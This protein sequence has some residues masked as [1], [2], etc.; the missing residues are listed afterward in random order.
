MSHTLSFYPAPKSAKQQAAAKWWRALRGLALLLAYAGAVPAAAQTAPSALRAKAYILDLSQRRITLPERTFYIEQVVDGRAGRPPIGM[1]YRGMYD[2]QAPVL[3]R[4]SLEAEL[5]TWLQQQFPKRPTDHTVVL[6]VRQLGV[7]ET[8]RGTAKGA[9]ASADL[10]AD[11]YEHQSD[12][13]HF[14]RT[15]A[16]RVSDR[17]IGDNS[18]HAE[19]LASAL[20]I[21]LLQVLPTDW[22]RPQPA[23]SLAQLAS[24]KPRGMARPA[25]LRAAT[26]RRGLYFTIEQFLA[27][28]PDTTAELHI[29]TVGVHGVTTVLE[30]GVPTGNSSEWKG[31][32]VLRARMRTAKGDRIPSK[33]VWGFSDGR[34]AYFRQINYYRPLTRQSDFYTFVGAAPLDVTA[35]NRRALNNAMQGA[36]SGGFYDYGPAGNTGQPIVYSLDLRTGQTGPFPAPGQVVKRDTAFVYVYRPL[37]GSAEPQRVLLNDHQIGQL[38]PGETL[39]IPWPHFGRAMRIGL[40]T[41]GGPALLLTPSTATATYI[42][43]WPTSAFT[44]W[45]LMPAQQ[46]EAEVD[47][48]EKRRQE[49]R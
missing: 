7:N 29:D 5:G 42:R 15:V 14:V 22:G 41:P 43:L 38:Q 28:Q 24:D 6:C 3:F 36:A 1:I 39:E 49:A 40:G 34:Q 47:A 48:L 25:I 23:R 46:G 10:V 4:Q 30:P 17:G 33:E 27:N 13:Y 35:A 12:G 11:I 32:P 2:K 44:P 16:G 45:Q 31:T 37:G 9:I 20:C 19:H 21:S 26:P 8:V 18:D